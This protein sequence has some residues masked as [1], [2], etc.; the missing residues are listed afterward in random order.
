[1]EGDR[2]K[3]GIAASDHA[4]AHGHGRGRTVERGY[5]AAGDPVGSHHG[6]A[7]QSQQ[8]EVGCARAPDDVVAKVDMLVV[9]RGVDQDGVPDVGVVGRLD[10]GIVVEVQRSLAEVLFVSHCVSA[11][12]NQRAGIL[13]TAD[14]H[15]SIDKSLPVARIRQD[16]RGVF[17]RVH[18]VKQPLGSFNVVVANDCACGAILQICAQGAVSQTPKPVVLHGHAQSLHVYVVLQPIVHGA[19]A[20]DVTPFDQDVAHQGCLGFGL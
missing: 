3:H 12:V 18:Q 7:G 17:L 10:D 15:V 9:G 19:I 8:V 11:V 6:L 1:M 16:I 2:V 5:V 13:G 20:E 4:R 14:E